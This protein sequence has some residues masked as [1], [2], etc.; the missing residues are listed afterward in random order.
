MAHTRVIT[1]NLK[2]MKDFTLHELSAT[3][4]ATWNCHVNDSGKGIYGMI[5]GRYLLI[6]LVLNLNSMIMSL[7]QMMEL[8]KV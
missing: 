3:E 1:T 6:D 4:I 8:L 7:M 2:V 5:L